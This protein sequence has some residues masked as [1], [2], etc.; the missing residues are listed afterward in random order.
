MLFGTSTDEKTAHRFLDTAYENGIN[1][2]DTAEMYPVPQCTETSGTSELIFGR[3]LSTKDRSSCVVATKVAGPG[4]M[5]WIRGGPHSIDSKNIEEA[6]DGSLC[7]LGIDCIDLFQIHWPDRYVPMFGDVDY[8]VK[9]KYGGIEIE[10]QMTALT[11]AVEK[12]KVRS[13]GLSNETP[14][15]VMKFRLADTGNTIVSIQNAYSLLC[16]TFDSGL[17]ECCSSEN[18]SLLAYSPLAMGLLTGKYLSPDGGPPHARLNKYRGRYAEAESRYGP[19]PN[20]RNAVAAYVKLAGEWGMLPVH[21]AIR[22][23]LDHPLVASAVTGV[24]SLEQLEQVVMAARAP[25]L[26][27]ELREAIDKIHQHYPNPTP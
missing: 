5:D 17:A 20:V 22:F 18:I 23:V 9:M 25:P 21:M 4:G 7:R 8:D 2:F 24:T 15:G 10:E 13:I 12:G 11:R 6:I 26:P 27:H 1:F 19:K 16:R 3:W 14:Y